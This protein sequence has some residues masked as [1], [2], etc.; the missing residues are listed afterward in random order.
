MSRPKIVEHRKRYTLRLLPE[1]LERI[2]TL[3]DYAG[4]TVSEY[5]RRC[6]LQKRIH[7]K[8]NLKAMGALARL[9]G[10]QKYCLQQIQDE[11]GL[12][13]TRHQLN[14]VLHEIRDEIQRLQSSEP[15]T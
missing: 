6:A 7:S 4:L 13:E 12:P 1:E 3:A 9:G 14:R 2:E 11:P 10:L 15:E 8:I 5:M